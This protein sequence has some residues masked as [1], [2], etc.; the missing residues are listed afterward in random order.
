MRQIIR[1][2]GDFCLAVPCVRLRCRGFASPIYSARQWECAAGA[3]SVK[4]A[5]IHQEKIS[6]EVAGRDAVL[7]GAGDFQKM[8]DDAN[9]EI[10]RSA[11]DLLSILA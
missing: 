7:A 11:R 4:E 6:W 8:L 3:V 5:E 9:P 2:T 10:S 1:A